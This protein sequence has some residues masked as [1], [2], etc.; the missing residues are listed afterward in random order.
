MLNSIGI[1]TCAAAS[2]VTSESNVGMSFQ[3][4]RNCVVE[5]KEYPLTEA[6]FSSI[7]NGR[8]DVIIAAGNWN[9]KYKIA[10]M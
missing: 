7:L 10:E 3:Y 8:A 4:S 6:S 1:D 5:G 2:R 9:P